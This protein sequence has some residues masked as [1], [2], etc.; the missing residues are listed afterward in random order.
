MDTDS[1]KE[2]DH[3]LQTFTLGSALATSLLLETETKR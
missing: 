3:V 2:D 1:T